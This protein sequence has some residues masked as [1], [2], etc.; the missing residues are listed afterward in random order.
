MRSIEYLII[1]QGLAGTLFAYEL[2]KHGHSFIIVDADK[3]NASKTAAGLYN[4]VVLKRFTGVWQG[5]EQIATAKQTMSELATLLDVKLDYP[6][7]ILRIFHDDNEKV[8][9]QKKQLNYRVYSILLF[10]I[11]LMQKLK[12]LMGSVVYILLEK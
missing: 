12:H 10:I 3:H 1:G 4:P 8:R 7:D 9:W 2:E 5:L 11:V 6:M